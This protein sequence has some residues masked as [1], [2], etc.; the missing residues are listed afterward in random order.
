MKLRSAGVTL[1][2]RHDN[3]KIAAVEDA[4]HG[5]RELCAN[6]IAWESRWPINT[7]RA[8]DASKLSQAMLDLGA[9]AEALTLDDYR[10]D[11]TERARRRAIYQSLEAEFDACVTLAAPGRG[12]GRPRLDGR[13][14][15]RNS[16]LD[17]R[18]SGDL[19]PRPSG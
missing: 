16:R 12:S 18:R 17:A 11:I 14:G 3:E 2:S 9:R 8:R 4:I 6:I 19:A 5:A 15:V 10:R 1:A 13:P 7:Y